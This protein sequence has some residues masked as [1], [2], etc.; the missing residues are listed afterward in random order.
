MASNIS[1]EGLS[2]DELLDLRE[3]ID[4]RLAK[5]VDAE[6]SD[7]QKRMDRLCKYKESPKG[8]STGERKA[9][10][11][12]R[13]KGRKAPIKF[14]DPKTGN[15]WSGRGLTPVWLREFEAN[16]GKRSDLAV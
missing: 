5:L 13:S 2:V 7:L 12:R 10:R 8:R 4:E 14:R 11:P 9:S 3:I 16:G 6:I 1:L 15:S